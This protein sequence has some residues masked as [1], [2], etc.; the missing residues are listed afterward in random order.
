[1]MLPMV[2]FGWTE[3][4][5]GALTILA[6]IGMRK[7]IATDPVDDLTERVRHPIRWKLTHPIRAIR[8]SW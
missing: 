4:A 8:R 5:E 1:M 6:A 2:A 7:A 3:F